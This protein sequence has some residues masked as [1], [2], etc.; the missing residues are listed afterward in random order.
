LSKNR[1]IQTKID[2]EVDQKKEEDMIVM[3]KMENMIN[4]NKKEYKREGHHHQMKE[5][6]I[7][8]KKVDLHLSNVQNIL[9]KIRNLKIFNKMKDKFI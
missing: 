3:I 1:N 7:N 4:L 2:R 8:I 5:I 6:E 9:L